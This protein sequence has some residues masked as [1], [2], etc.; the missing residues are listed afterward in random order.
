[1]S[2]TALVQWM[3]TAIVM[4]L[5]AAIGGSSPAPAP[6]IVTYFDLTYTASLDHPDR[7]EHD[8]SGPHKTI[9]LD[10]IIRNQ[11]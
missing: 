11:Y 9:G 10:Q 3:V 7:F 5:A 4:A 6:K 2:T 8:E 1:M